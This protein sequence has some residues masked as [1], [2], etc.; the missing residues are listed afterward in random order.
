[1]QTIKAKV[2]DVQTIRAS[3]SSP[4]NKIQV[5]TVLSGNLPTFNP[6][7]TGTVN[8]NGE[9]VLAQGTE[10]KHTNIIENFLDNITKVITIGD[11]TVDR[12]IELY[13]SMSNGTDLVTGVLEVSHDGTNIFPDD[14][15]TINNED[16][17]T[18]D[19]TV[20]YVGNDIRLNLNGGGIGTPIEFKYFINNKIP[21]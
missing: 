20:T 5:K 21:I 19:F 2:N 18:V 14:E 4:Q 6:D 15:R 17:E 8:I 16:I 1:M 3:V 11:R 9:L 13:Y 10:I 12:V 7:L